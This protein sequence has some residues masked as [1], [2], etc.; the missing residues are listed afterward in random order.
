V[1]Q[2]DQITGDLGLKMFIDVQ[3]RVVIRQT[4]LAS[5]FKPDNAVR[6]IAPHHPGQ[7]VAHQVCRK[8]PRR[9]PADVLAKI[10]VP[11]RPRR[12][13][14]EGLFLECG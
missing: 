5:C 3:K 12:R 7:A 4:V 2:C 6:P 10:D 9:I 14:R 1:A 13:H 8:T 11:D